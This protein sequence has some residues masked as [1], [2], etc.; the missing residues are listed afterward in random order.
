MELRLYVRPDIYPD[1][2]SFQPVE[3]RLP[4]EDFFIDWRSLLAP[5]EELSVDLLL[6]SLFIIET[7]TIADD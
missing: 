5:F 1:F 3:K 6:L 4:N 2:Y 7:R